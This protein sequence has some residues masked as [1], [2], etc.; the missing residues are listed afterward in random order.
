MTRVAVCLVSLFLLTGW[1]IGQPQQQQRDSLQ[2]NPHE[3]QWEWANPQTDEMRYNPHQ[4]TW[5]YEDRGS[6]LQYNPYSRTWDYV[7]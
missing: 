4:N 5:G 3:R 2:Y 7:D 6:S 1:T